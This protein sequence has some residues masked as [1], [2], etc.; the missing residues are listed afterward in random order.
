[1]FKNATAGGTVNL[2]ISHP[3]RLKQSIIPS[4]PSNLS[5]RLLERRKSSEDV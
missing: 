3:T 2:D 5:Y 1:M 4:H